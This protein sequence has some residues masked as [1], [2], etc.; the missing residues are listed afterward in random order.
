TF[1]SDHMLKEAWK[2]MTGGNTPFYAGGL[3]FTYNAGAGGVQVF[4][5]TT[6]AAVA[7]LECGPGHWNSVI[8]ADN[9]IALPEGS[10]SGFGGGFGR[11]RGTAPAPTP[12]APA[13][14][15]PG[16]V[17]IWRLP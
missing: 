10:I 14:P 11:G 8:V 7:T 3:L 12:A 5:A 16:I 2:N 6:G 15:P 13:T 17:N 9:R 1:G 4:N